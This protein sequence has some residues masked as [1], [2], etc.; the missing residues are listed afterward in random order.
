MKPH[1]SATRFYNTGL[2]CCDSFL[3]TPSSLRSLLVGGACACACHLSLYMCECVGFTS[4]AGCPQK[5]RGVPGRLGRSWVRVRSPCCLVTTA[6]TPRVAC[7]VLGLVHISKLA[8]GD[9]CASVRACCDGFG[10]SLWRVVLCCVSGGG[11]WCGC[12]CC[13]A[14][15]LCCGRPAPLAVWPAA[16]LHAVHPAYTNHLSHCCSQCMERPCCCLLFL[17]VCLRVSA[18]HNNPVCVAAG[19]LSAPMQVACHVPAHKL[20]PVALAVPFQL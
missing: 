16:A 17:P 13:C 12:G 14:R 11:L 6:R 5:K 20:C 19:M 7:V 8:G 15:V 4:P 3:L 10:L 1:S 18:A 9:V 2:L